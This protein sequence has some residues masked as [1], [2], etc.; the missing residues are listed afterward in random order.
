MKVIARCP[1]RVD[2]A[3]GTLDLWPLFNFLGGAVTIN[4]AID[5]YTEAELTK[6]KTSEI[7]IE[8]ENTKFKKSFKD[9]NSFFKDS[10]DRIADKNLH[11]I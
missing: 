6:L 11:F 5:I 10:T 4:A 1:T 3:G 7:I 9:L 8:I 2:L